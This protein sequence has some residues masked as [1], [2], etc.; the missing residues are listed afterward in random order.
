MKKLLLTLVGI[1]LAISANATQWFVSGAFQGWN[2]CNANYEL[3]ETTSGVYEL[4]FTQPM[5]MS[6]EFLIVQGTVGSPDWN[7]K[8]GTNGSK[9]NLDTPYTY[10]AGAGN[11]SINGVLTVSKI[12]LDT[13]NTTL[14]LTGVQAENDYD[15]VYMVGDFGS[16]WN[17]GA[18]N[19]THPLALK[20]GTTNVWEADYTLTAKSYI[21]LRAGNY[22]YATGGADVNMVSG[23]TYTATQEGNAFALAAGTYH[24]EFVLDKNADSGLFTATADGDTPEPTPDYSSWYVNVI[25]NFNSWVDN[26]LQ[27]VDGIT[28]HT[29]L[30]IGNSEFKVKVWNG[31]NDVYYSTGT[32]IAQNEWV[33]IDGDAFANMT[34]AGATEG[35][36]FD[37]EFDC[38]NSSIKV[39][40]VSGG[41]TP[42]PPTPPTPAEQPLN[43][44][45]VFFGADN[46][47]ANFTPELPAIGDWAADGTTGNSKIAV[48]P[49]SEGG[50]IPSFSC[51]GITIAN[52]K[53]TGATGTITLSS[54]YAVGASIEAVAFRPY[55]NNTITVT[56]PEG[57]VF[58]KMEAVT[59]TSTASAKF[60]FSN[61]TAV[62][63]TSNK[64]FTWTPSSDDVAEFIFTV[65]ATVQIRTLTF[66]LAKVE[67][68]VEY[69]T[70]YLRG[71]INGWGMGDDYKF[72]EAD[73]IYTLTVPV[74]EG[75]FKI[76]EE[77]WNDA[78]SATTNNRAMELDTEY[79]TE[80]GAGEG[81]NMAMAAPKVLDATIVY[82][83]L[84]GT[85]KVT[86]TIPI[87][88]YPTL[89][90]RGGINNWGTGDDY[91]FAQTD[92]IYTLTIPALE[93]DFKIADE[94]WS[95]A[96]TFS[97]GNNAMELNTEYT[98]SGTSENMKMAATKVLD[99]TFTFDYN[100]Q[101]LKVTGT[102]PAVIT[103]PTLYLRGAVN[104][105]GAPD[106]YK[107]SETD[108]VYTLTID[109]LSGEFKIADNSWGTE[110]SNG[111]QDMQ[112]ATTYSTLPKSSTNMKMAD[113]EIAN[114]TIVYNAV[115]N[116]IEITGSPVSD[117]VKTYW[118]KG[119]F[120]GWAD[121]EMTAV[122]DADIYTYAFTA[123]SDND[124]AAF[125][126][127]ERNNGTD[128]LYFKASGS[129]AL[130]SGATVTLVNEGNDIIFNQVTGY[131]YTFTFDPADNS[132]EFKADSNTGL[133]AV[134]A[135]AAEAVY[136]NLQGVRV[137]NPAAGMYIRIQGSHVS[138]VVIR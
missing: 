88:E 13:N 15:T 3:T 34:I 10:R 136:Y 45:F 35:M 39:T 59:N 114:V 67:D 71:A 2:H 111:K 16:G 20:A 54:L 79:A 66:T 109:K 7:N 110:V 57:Y 4:A 46:N 96:Y 100:N 116:T 123:T 129:D 12:T 81:N 137:E 53:T 5:T 105:W 124:A 6:G 133:E 106:A 72:A 48:G 82:N 44:N 91:K 31:T 14:L 36:I 52:Q 127:F 131:L 42:E 8:I 102:V 62:A 61:G 87:F 55:K 93:G 125:V 135:N 51:D 103:Y 119:T 108:G 112:L 21:K 19:T 22:L 63:G 138:K 89:Y 98:T 68:P 94:N 117:I 50:K 120:N 38:A 121:A 11:F 85:L 74:L 126:I 99:V 92:G 37:V 1:V 40:Y 128:G 30:A 86:G 78:T 97:T 9:I 118:I 23:E 47:L 24:F 130:V 29:N 33:A 132:L 73:G 32:A 95:G 26:G 43:V 65:S 75:E 76:A 17:D 27:P 77:N 18:S 101:T 84:N 41:E 80:S 115:A 104:N 25:G 56:A 70:L 60:T 107:F 134:E 28:K 90:L 64:D 113:A 122:P 83:S 58:E 69:P 49:E